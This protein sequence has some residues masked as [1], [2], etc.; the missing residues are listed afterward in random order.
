M[1][2]GGTHV[3]FTK[4]N[5][6]SCKYIQETVCLILLHE[7]VTLRR[8]IF[9]GS[10]CFISSLAAVVTNRQ[11]PCQMLACFPLSGTGRKW[12]GERAHELR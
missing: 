12:E 2:F 9:E 1:L 6:M 11:G 3:I 7:K 4:I 5:C 10:R 8:Y